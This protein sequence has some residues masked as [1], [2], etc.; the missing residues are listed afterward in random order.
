MTLRTLYD[1]G[2]FWRNVSRGGPEI[3][4]TGNYVENYIESGFEATFGLC[5]DEWYPLLQMRDSRDE[6]SL[7]KSYPEGASPRFL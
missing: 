3:F 1:G 2:I 6:K 5:S 7:K 4:L